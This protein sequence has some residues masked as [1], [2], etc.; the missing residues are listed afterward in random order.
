[1]RSHLKIEY[2]W[3]MHM[4]KIARILQIGVLYAL[5]CGAMY[6]MRHA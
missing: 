2:I 1:M 3:K 5:I 6:V 4:N